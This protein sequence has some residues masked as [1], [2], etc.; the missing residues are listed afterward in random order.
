MIEASLASGEGSSGLS[1]GTAFSLRRL[2]RFPA[3]PAL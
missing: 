3:A 2:G 1:L